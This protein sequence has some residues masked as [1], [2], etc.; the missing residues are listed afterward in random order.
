M[1]QLTAAQRRFYY[2]G[3]DIRLSVKAGAAI[4]E[5]SLLGVNG[6]S[7]R[8]LTAGDPFAGI[9]LEDRTG[10]ASDGLEHVQTR[11]RGRVALPLGGVTAADVGKRVYASDG[12]TITLTEGTNSSVGAIIALNEA[13]QPIVAFDADDISLEQV[14]LHTA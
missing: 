13:G 5:G 2:E 1:A 10:G 4:F 3:N 7:V 11:R 14:A 6:G 9:A 12:N 8:Q